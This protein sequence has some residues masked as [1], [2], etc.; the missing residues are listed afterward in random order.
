MLAL[1]HEHLHIWAR[2]PSGRFVLQS[3]QG[4]AYRVY[5]NAEPLDELRAVLPPREADLLD[6][7]TVVY[8]SDRLAP[9]T[10]PNATADERVHQM[11][12]ARKLR[13]EV[14]VREPSYWQSKEISAALKAVLDELTGDSWEFVFVPAQKVQGRLVQ[15]RHIEHNGR[16]V[17]LF[18]GGLDSLAGL[19]AL[20]KNS[21]VGAT[22]VS[23]SSHSHLKHLQG[24]LVT[25]L[26]KDFA[27]EFEQLQVKINHE[28]C[29]LHRQGRDQRARSFFYF[30]VAALT[31]RRRGADAI[32]VLENG[33]TSLNLPINPLLTST[34]ATRT[35]H[36]LV[37]L[38]FER[39]VRGALDW[40]TFRVELPHLRQTK[41]EMVLPFATARRSMIAATVSC[42][43]VREKKWCGTCTAC[44]LRRQVLWAVGLRDLDEEEQKFY[45]CDIFRDFA[46]ED[47]AG[48]SNWYFLAT[49]DH[50]GSI[51]KDPTF[52]L[53]HP[54]ILR[55]ASAW[56]ASRGID[57]VQLLQEL[58]EMHLR[59]AREWQSV[60]VR[61][62]AR[63][64]ELHKL[65][66]RSELIRSM[67]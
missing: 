7:A 29:D 65:A 5:R 39:L 10:W 12:W 53:D 24:D 16:P 63:Y 62:G 66:L 23:I 38:A 55:V 67:A 37:L 22:L 35:T 8:G 60:F 4:V 21:Q 52:V 33:V 14:P 9:R 49:L 41:A 2:E 28:K 64:G 51:L 44:L 46:Q 26:R 36:P 32:H 27:G 54:S 31:A 25:A 40:A 3:G 15:M 30:V 11:N 61:T 47:F 20:V 50:V 19:L 18:S 58:V 43:R 48:H 6:I 42:A 1:D 56:A 59:Y 17:V 34:R 45:R 13:L 57:P